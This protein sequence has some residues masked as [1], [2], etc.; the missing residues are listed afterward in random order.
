MQDNG[1]RTTDE[2]PGLEPGFRTFALCL[3]IF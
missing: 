3:L 1:K 2:N